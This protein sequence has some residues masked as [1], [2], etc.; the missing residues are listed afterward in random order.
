MLEYIPHSESLVG[1]HRNRTHGR[2]GAA[3]AFLH[4]E[5][6]SNA[7][8][9]SEN[10]TVDQGFPN[11]F[12]HQPDEVG[13]ACGS[14]EINQPMQYLPAFAKAPDPALSGCQREWNHEHETCEAGRNEWTLVDVLDD[15][16]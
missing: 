14:R 1:V 13:D 15:R 16:V 4:P 7:E 3:T 10:R 8:E 12:L 11:I 9:Y 5:N 6:N 2:G